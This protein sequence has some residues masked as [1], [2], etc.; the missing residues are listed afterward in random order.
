V[1]DEIIGN[2]NLYFLVL[3]R[4]LALVELAPLLSSDAIPQFAKF[5]LAGFGAFVAYPA[6][7]ASGYPVPTNGLEYA[8]VLVGEALVGVIIALFLDTVYAAFLAAGQFFSLHIGF[9]A[10]EVFDPLAQVEIPLMGQYLNNVAMFAFLTI[11]GFQK[12]FLVGI[13]NSFMA[14]RAV[15]LALNR[16]RFLQLLFSGLSGL[17][18]QAFLIALPILGTL[19]LITI[20]MG[21]LSKAAPQMNLM[22]EGFSISISVAFVMM[23]VS[24]PVM[25]ETFARVVDNGFSVLEAFYAQVQ[26]GPR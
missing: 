19:I 14:F 5:A 16:E 6:V 7:Q 20:A 23:L 11:G 3:A 17:F 15:D 10:S 8:A 9:G 4:V 25:V 24:M 22:T 12:L 1:L 2:A 26:G 21:L 13:Q 18:Q